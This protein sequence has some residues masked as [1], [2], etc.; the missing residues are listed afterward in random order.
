MGQ[1]TCS[2]HPDLP[3]DKYLRHRITIKKCFKVLMT[4]QLNLVLWRLINLL[5]FLSWA[6]YQQ[7]NIPICKIWSLL[8]LFGNLSHSLHEWVY[9]DGLMGLTL[10][11]NNLFFSFMFWLTARLLKIQ[12]LEKKKERKEGI[13]EKKRKGKERKGKERKEEKRRE[14]KRKEKKRKEKKRKEKKRKEKKRKEK[15]RGCF[16]SQNPH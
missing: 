6:N 9:T 1:Q 14:E 2:A 12:W 5:C 15:K 10:K 11:R 3:D 13:K 16:T 4:Q 8:M 7:P